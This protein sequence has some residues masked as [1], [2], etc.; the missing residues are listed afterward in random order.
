[1]ANKSVVGI[2]YIHPKYNSVLA[3]GVP[4]PDTVTDYWPDW[5]RVTTYNGRYSG[6]DP[7][8]FWSNNGNLGGLSH[9]NGIIS[10]TKQNDNPKKA[11][12]HEVGHATKDFFERQVLGL[13]DPSASD[14]EFTDRE[15]KILRGIKQ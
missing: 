1:M 6:I 13:M 3:G 4:N 2:K 12:A 8:S 11:I 10:I 5:V 9:G 7:D 14:D 15:K